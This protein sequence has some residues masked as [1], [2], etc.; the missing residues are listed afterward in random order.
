MPKARQPLVPQRQ[1]KKKGRPTKLNPETQAKICDA[2]RAGNYLETAAAYAG[3]DKTTLFDWLRKGARAK[4][5]IHKEFSQAVEKAMAD[6]ET[7]DVAL[8]GK[9]ANNGTWQ[10]SAWR[11]ERKYP[12][13]W[14]RRDHHRIDAAVLTAKVDPNDAVQELARLLARRVAGGGE[15]QA[16]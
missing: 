12:D 3:I 7:R 13:R 11:L 8:I 4:R 1:A 6:A 14:G 5:G 16:T 15:D 10:A 9:A 2:L